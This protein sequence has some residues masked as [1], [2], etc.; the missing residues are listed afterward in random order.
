MTFSLTLYRVGTRLLE[1]L[2]PW[3]VS[4]RVEKGKEN[5]ERIGERFGA[6]QAA[7][8]DGVLIWM[9]GASVG[10]SRLLVDVRDSVV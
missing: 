8:P 6:T 3:L 7:R 10:E 4:R 5:P 1:P 2:A 9:H